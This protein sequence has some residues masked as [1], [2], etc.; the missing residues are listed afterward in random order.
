MT[1]I[2]YSVKLYSE[3]HCS[4]GLS[5]GSGDDLL[6][7]KDEKNLPIIPGKTLKGLIRDAA[8]TLLDLKHVS[9]DFVFNVFGV[10]A[11]TIGLCHFSTAELSR[12][13]REH[14]KSEE[15]KL[16]Y[17]SRASTAI[18]ENGLA[19]KH[20]LRRMETTIP[21]S[22]FARVYNVPFENMEDMAKCIR[23]VKHIG[24]NRNRGLGRCDMIVLEEVAI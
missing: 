19:V 4:S 12:K 20:S 2:T 10:E 5:A 1:D 7:I 17:R 15:I 16:L 22:L 9:E 8:E 6:V 23:F 11:D 18:D 14:I 21:L 13:R 3:W 24:I